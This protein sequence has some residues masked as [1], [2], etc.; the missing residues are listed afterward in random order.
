MKNLKTIILGVFLSIVGISSIQAQDEE[1][2]WALGFGVNIVDIN[3][4]GLSDVL[5][6][7]KD[8]LGTKDWNAIPAISTVTVS[9]YMNYGLSVGVSASFNKIDTGLAADDSDGLSFYA[10]NVAA[11]YDLNSIDFIGDTSWFDPYVELG[12]GETWID[13][14]AA[15]T[16]KAG[17]GFNTWFNEHVGMNFDAS[18][19]SGTQSFASVNTSNYFQH[20]IGL[21][22]RFNGDE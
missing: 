8:G 13:N 11:K 10:V 9:R 14:D 7:L 3:K 1:N 15:F 18:F 5:S 2:K 6:T 17:L 12:L 4:D 19:N 21:I 22:I 16:I 20:S